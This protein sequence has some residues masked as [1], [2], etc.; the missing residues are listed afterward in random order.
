MEEIRWILTRYLSLYQ[1]DVKVVSIYGNT[2]LEM[3]EIINGVLDTVVQH[4]K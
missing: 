2:E 4:M 1:K 3:A